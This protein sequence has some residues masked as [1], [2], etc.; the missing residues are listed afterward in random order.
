MI[1]VK[2]VY[3][4]TKELM[5]EKPSSTIYDNYLIGNL[6]R[7]LVELFNENNVA[8][9]FNGKQKLE[10]PQVLPKQNYQDIEIELEDEYARNV[11][12]LG[13]AAR[14]FIDDDLSKYAMYST[15][16]NNARVINQKLISKEKLNATS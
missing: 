7:L 12:P 1:T 10:S 8:R 4:L 16:Y 6:N 5:F 11:L 13:L 3:T 14:F 2:E 15:D 9:V